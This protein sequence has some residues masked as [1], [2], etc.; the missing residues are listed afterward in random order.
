MI[1]VNDSATHNYLHNLE[2]FKI[3]I[4]NNLKGKNEEMTKD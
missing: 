3:N 1:A 2:E 4:V